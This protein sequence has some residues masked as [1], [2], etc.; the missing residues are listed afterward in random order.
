MN[1]ESR[2]MEQYIELQNVIQQYMINGQF[3]DAEREVMFD[4][5]GLQQD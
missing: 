2:K 3:V 4:K 1:M 5:I